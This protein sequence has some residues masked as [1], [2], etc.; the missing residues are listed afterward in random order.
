V[1]SWALHLAHRPAK[2]RGWHPTVR[3]GMQRTPA[4]AQEASRWARQLHDGGPRCRA[5]CPETAAYLR[6]V[7]PALVDWSTHYD[8]LREV[9]RDDVLAC[10]SGLRGEARRSTV[11][12]LRSLFGWAR[13][14]GVIFRNPATGIRLGKRDYPVWQP[15]APPDI[16]AAVAAASTPHAQLFVAL[17]AIHAARPGE[18][19]A[20]HLDDVDLAG[21]RLTV[22]GHERPLDA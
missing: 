22:A 15:L 9:T 11:T 13:R 17:A 14:S 20:L 4:I 1:A 2:V 8:H 7:R 10:L 12:A 5:R 19:R 6:W 21:R 16:A 18:I 3:R